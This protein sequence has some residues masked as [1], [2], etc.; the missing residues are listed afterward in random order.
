MKP[1]HFV[2]IRAGL[3]R[4]DL[5]Q[6]LTIDENNGFLRVRVVPR[7]PPPVYDKKKPKKR[8]RT[9][10]FR[11]GQNQCFPGN[12][13]HI[14]SSAKIKTLQNGFEF[15]GKEFDKDGFRIVKYYRD[16]VS[17]VKPTLMEIAR[18]IDATVEHVRRTHLQ[19]ETGTLKYYSDRDIMEVGNF[20]LSQISK[21][22]S[23]ISIGHEVEIVEGPSKGQLGIAVASP[24]NGNV[25]VSFTDKDA[26]TE[27]EVPSDI[28]RMK[29]NVGESVFVKY[30]AFAGRMGLVEG[31]DHETVFFRE[32]GTYEEVSEEKYIEIGNNSEIGRCE[33]RQSS[34][35]RTQT[36]DR[37]IEQ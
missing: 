15:R 34:L 33:Q 7:L 4:Q 24:E 14:Y 1:G 29:F 5:A 30:G 16:T 18:F 6:V 13:Q 3:Y 22:E 11:P 28:V 26:A 19:S 21:D 27:E 35:S 31:G 9:R 36:T 20:D 17:V 2:Q 12:L 25:V 37:H 23:L 32:S 10:K 8:A